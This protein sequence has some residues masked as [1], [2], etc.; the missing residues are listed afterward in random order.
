MNFSRRALTKATEERVELEAAAATAKSLQLC[1]TLCDPMDSSPPGS[2]APGILQARTLE[3]VAIS[4]SN[5]LKWNV[6]VKSL[7]GVRLFATPWTAAHQA[8]PSMGFS[9]QEYWSGMPLSSPELEAGGSYLWEGTGYL[10]LFC[11]VPDTEGMPVCPGGRK[12]LSGGPLCSRST[13]SQPGSS[14]HLLH[15]LQEQDACLEATPMWECSLE[16]WL[17]MQR[18][19]PGGQG[20]GQEREEIPF[21]GGWRV[22]EFWGLPHCWWKKERHCREDKAPI[23]DQKLCLQALL[24]FDLQSVH[25]TPTLE[26]RR[27]KRRTMWRKLIWT[28]RHA[29]LQGSVHSTGTRKP[30]RH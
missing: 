11:S 25:K 26:G 1:L 8:P 17:G 4:F 3:W 19:C 16:T 21:S 30:L 9:R 10:G 22:G 24:D 15:S 23:R 13:W 14:W 6:K 29:G 7:S 12:G 2:P 28:S 27:E 18:S 5:A 20:L